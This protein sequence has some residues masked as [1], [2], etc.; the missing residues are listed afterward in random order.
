MI[1]KEN[2]Y[3]ITIVF[4]L[5]FIIQF[6]IGNTLISMDLNKLYWLMYFTLVIIISTKLKISDIAFRKERFFLYICILG[7]ASTYLMG[8]K[9]GMVFLKILSI[10]TGFVG[11]IYLSKNK[12]DLRFFSLLMILLYIYFSQVYFSEKTFMTDTDNEYNLFGHSSSNL[13][14][15]ALNGVLM[16]YYIINK[17][18]NGGHLRLLLLF[19]FVNLIFI[20][21]QASRIGVFV[22]V[23]LS[24][25][26][27]YD[28]YKKD[29]KNRFVYFALVIFVI[30]FCI[31]RMSLID[32]YILLVFDENINNYVEDCR[33][34]ARMAVFDQMTRTTAIFGA[35]PGTTYG[36]LGRTFNAFL[37]FWANYGIFPVLVLLYNCI[38][39][40][41]NRHL[42]I[43]PLYM[44]FPLC[45]YS[46]V[47]TYCGNTLW[48]IWIFIALYYS[49]DTSIIKN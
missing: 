7:A 49:K 33:A 32:K 40:C 8:V 31:S 44:L 30:A 16:F 37:D 36:V 5:V 12:I 13:S 21:I 26:I 42:Y 38:L 35:I 45:L 4:I 25:M 10:Y 15:H 34:I 17:K 9:Y 14:S 41:L 43:V 3:I 6:I 23:L 48:D 22:S 24:I 18:Q 27:L 46:F 29:G 1:L 28:N 47:E 2:N 11:Y 39:R 20:V 19:S